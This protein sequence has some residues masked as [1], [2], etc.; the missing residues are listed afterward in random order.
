MNSLYKQNLKVTDIMGTG[1][2]MLHFKHKKLIFKDSLSFLNMP[3]ANFTKTLGLV[4]LKK[5]FFPHKFSKLENLQ[6]EGEIPPLHFYEPQHMDE[7]KKK[8]C[9]VRHAEQVAKGEIWNFQQEFLS[10]CESDVRLMKV[11][12]IPSP[13]QSTNFTAVSFM[14]ARIVNLTTDM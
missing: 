4:K 11:V 8:A 6:Y 2:R 14:A 13:K 9:E 10:Y 3:L 1:T 12:V 5:G 7:E